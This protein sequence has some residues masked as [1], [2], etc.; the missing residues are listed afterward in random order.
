MNFVQP[1]AADALEHRLAAIVQAYDNQGSHRT[2]TAVDHESAQWL[3]EC[4]RRLG[5]EATLEPFALNRIDPQPSYL[6]I[7]DRCIGGLPLFDT[8]FTGPD[9]VHGRLGTLGSDAEIAVIES[10]PFTLMEPQKEQRD[11]VATARRTGH[12]AVVVLTRGT[13]PGLFLLNALSFKTP[14][15]PPMLQVSSVEAA[16]LKQQAAAQAQAVRHHVADG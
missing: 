4:A 11:A 5:V 10:E 7:G 6:R 16:W 2:G 12:K 15:G 3:V 13:F 9:G 14:S 1:A 8:A